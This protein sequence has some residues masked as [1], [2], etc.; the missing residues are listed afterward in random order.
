MTVIN[1]EHVVCAGLY[2]KSTVTT[3]PVTVQIAVGE[4]HNDDERRQ[5]VLQNVT[6]VFIAPNILQYNA[7]T[8]R[9]VSGLPLGPQVC[10]GT[11]VCLVCPMCLSNVGV[12]WP[13]GGMDQDAT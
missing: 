11:V 3:L 5:R 2:R 6:G 8:I 13:N 10:N 12:L 4:L 1:V 9:R 7:T